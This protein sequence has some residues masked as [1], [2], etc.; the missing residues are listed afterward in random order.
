M[1]KTSLTL[2]IDRYKVEYM[3]TNYIIMFKLDFFNMDVV[4]ENFIFDSI[5]DASAIKNHNLNNDN[6][7]DIYIEDVTYSTSI[8]T[9]LNDMPNTSSRLYNNSKWLMHYNIQGLKSLLKVEEFNQLLIKLDLD[10]ICLSE[11]WL[12]KNEL[13]LLQNNIQNYTL[14]D[15]YCRKELR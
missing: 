15:F 3:L 7:F 2:T 10:V 1:K 4:S 8:E 6:T 5:C 14:A 9:Y 11:H 13:C 12:K